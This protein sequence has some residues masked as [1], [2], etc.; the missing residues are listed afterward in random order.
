MTATEIDSRLRQLGVVQ[1]MKVTS[2]TALPFDGGETA[3]TVAVVSFIVTSFSRTLIGKTAELTWDA[4]SKFFRSQQK[5]PGRVRL[6]F[7][8]KVRSTE[9]ELVAEYE[10]WKMA[11]GDG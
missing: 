8:T 3:V 10:T 6:V 9:I 2:T 11:N 7:S 5:A 1:S 4:I